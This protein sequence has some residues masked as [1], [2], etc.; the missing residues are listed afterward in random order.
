MSVY[1][2]VKPMCLFVF[3]LKLQTVSVFV[4]KLIE[5]HD[6]GIFSITGSQSFGKIHVF[7]SCQRLND[8][9]VLVMCAFIESEVS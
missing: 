3:A 6:D 2:L 5:T 8:K 4:E 1:T 7:V 9:M